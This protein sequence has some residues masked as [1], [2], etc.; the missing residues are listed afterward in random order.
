[1][2][3][4]IQGASGN[5]NV[6]ESIAGLEPQQAIRRMGLGQKANCTQFILCICRMSELST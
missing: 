3:Q 6:E 2:T 5:L 4:T 1:M